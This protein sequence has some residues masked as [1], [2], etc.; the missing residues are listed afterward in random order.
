MA[1]TVKYFASVR[2]YMGKRQDTIV[3]DEVKVIELLKR[4]KGIK[5]T[6]D[7]LLLKNGR[8]KSIYTIVVN[9]RDINS[10]NGLETIV[11]DGDV[12]AIF[13]PFSGG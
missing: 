13:P 4:L 6:L 9:G 12:V 7:K 10:L 2:E 3:V 8:L 5:G 11:K 1:I